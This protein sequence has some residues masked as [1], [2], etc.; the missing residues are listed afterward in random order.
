MSAWRERKR[1]N[2][3][4]RAT[5]FPEG[6]HLLVARNAGHDMPSEATRNMFVLCIKIQPANQYAGDCRKGIAI[7]IGERSKPVTL[8]TNL[9][10]FK[11]AH[12]FRSS[13]LP[14][15]HRIKMPVG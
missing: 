4:K 10:H 1:D 9:D 15:L 8:A 7:E 6:L 12:F 13:L 2:L 3:V 5:E 11:E 14:K